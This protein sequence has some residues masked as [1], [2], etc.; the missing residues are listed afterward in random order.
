MFIE[1]RYTQDTTRETFYFTVYPTETL[2][3]PYFI[4][5]QTLDGM[6]IDERKPNQYPNFTSY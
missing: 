6:Y 1:N 2:G 4:S 5:V 3:G